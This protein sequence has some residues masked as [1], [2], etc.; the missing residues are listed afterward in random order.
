MAEPKYEF[1]DTR[2]A[3][4]ANDLDAT[5]RK[6]MLERFKS[7]GGQVLKERDV[8]Q[9]ADASKAGGIET[10]GGRGGGSAGP[11]GGGGG[12]PEN[13]LPSELRREREREESEKAQ[14]A[15]AEY[16]K[17][18]KKI[19]GPGAKFMIRLRCFLAGVS[20][21]SGR[22]IKPSFV[23]FLN[24][25]VKQ[26]LIEFNLIG[27]DLFLQ[28][29]T[30]GKKITHSLDN[31]NPLL[32]ETLEYA[33]HMYNSEYFSN[34]AAAAQNGSSL[35]L[36]SASGSLKSIYRA[37]YILYPFQETF[38][39]AMGFALDVFTPEAQ[40]AKLS[41]ESIQGMII[42]QKRFNNNTKIVFQTAFSKLFH[43]ICLADGV[44]YPPFSPLLEKAIQVTQADKL[45][46]RKKGDTSTLE[47]GAAEVAGEAAGEGEVAEEKK[48]EE[49]KGG[50]YDTKEYQYGM[51]L[52]KLNQPPA[53]AQR[54]DTSKRMLEKVPI[55]DRILLAYLHFLEFDYEYSF[56]LTTNKIHIN[57]DY[58][59]GVKSDYKKQM[60]DLY[61]ESR[62]IIKAYEKYEEMLQEYRE[63]AARKSTNYIE[64][65]KLDDKA[66][67]RADMEGRNTRG[68]IRTFMDNVAKSMA[69]LIADMKSAKQIVGNMDEP[70]KFDAE[71]E[72]G[73]RLNGKPV[74]QCIMDAY[75]YAVAFKER[76]ANGDLFPLTPMTDEEMIASFGSTFGA[77][78]AAPASTEPAEM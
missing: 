57:V 41:Q 2:A 28:R 66:K 32:M 9:K 77:G 55:N 31:R 71:F 33:H 56:V 53:L 30:I 4:K 50:I 34:F 63:Q 52:M 39:K 75:C 35:P 70:V 12:V 21:F 25:E 62:A 64:K 18:L 46:Q 16:E 49:K 59:G 68:L 24:L 47:S 73:K 10:R 26:A 48:E 54:F 17:A 76:L 43:L 65:S 40:S 15:R 61:N 38:K 27:N 20:P 51:S 7:V 45:G 3:I 44:D 72:K 8:T 42:K 13:K 19:S 1:D 29:P 6:E 74:K 14:R 22:V 69:F 5:T 60:A 78:G 23:Q 11:G 36:E 37:L 58:S 67:G